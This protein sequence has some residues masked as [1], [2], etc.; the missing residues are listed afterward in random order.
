VTD[1]KVVDA[2]A[3]GALLF[4][5]PTGDTA[6]ARLRGGRLVAPTL[7]AYEITSVCLAKIRANHQ[8]RAEFLVAFTGWTGLGIELVEIDQPST[9]KL[10]EQFGLSSYDASY[11]WL[12]RRL[13]AELVTFDRRLAQAHARQQGG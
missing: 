2:S 7:L 1:I 10:A 6:A 8:Q 9:L 5:E 11:L 12:A 4:A 3:L 13:G